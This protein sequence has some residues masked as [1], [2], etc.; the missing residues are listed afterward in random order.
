[1]GVGLSLFGIRKDGTEFPVEISLS[2]LP[3]EE[4]PMVVSAIRDVTERARAEAKFRGLVESAPDAVVIVDRTG[5]MVIVNAQAERLFGRSRDDLLGQPVETLVPPRF[6]SGHGASREGYFARPHVR[7]MDS[8]M[9]LFGLRSDGTEFPAEIS[10]SPLETSEGTLVSCAIRDVTERKRL[11]EITREERRHA[12]EASR[13]KSEFLANMSHELRTP[14]NAVIGFAE[15]MHDGK[16]GPVA[17][18]QLEFLIDILTS[19]RHLLQ[20]INDVLDLSK[21]EAGKLEF[22]LER[23]ALRNLVSQVRDTLRGLALA[24]RIAITVEVAPEV[25]EVVADPARLK[26]ILYNYISNALKFTR[27]DGHVAVRAT[28][29]GEAFYRVEVKDDGIGIAPEDQQRLFVEF[30]QLDAGSGKKYGGTGLGLALTKRLVEAQGG[31]VGVESAVG[32]GS[33][34]YA[35]L[36]REARPVPSSAAFAA[37]DRPG[38]PCILVVEDD[39]AHRT[40]LEKAL[41]RAGY[42]V[43]SAADGA[44]ARELWRARVFDAITLDLVLPDT[45]GQE[46]LAGLRG[47]DGPNRYTPVVVVTAVEDVRLVPGFQVSQVLSKPVKDE[48]LVAALAEAGALPHA[49]G[50]ILVVDDEEFARRLAEETLRPL[51]YEA[52]GVGGGA[53]ALEALDA[54]TP[55]AIVLD[56]LMPGMNG[57]EFLRRLRERKDGRRV[58]VIAWTAKEPSEEERRTLTGLAQAVVLKSAGLAPLLHEVERLAYGGP[59]TEETARVG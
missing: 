35:V 14:L 59:S 17:P 6:R 2:P 15:L 46:L 48:Q 49:P 4:G 44:A 13:M 54:A 20:L 56:L 33:A 16:A 18:L 32:K 53:E 58:P 38:A 50:L 47:E 7:A 10:L 55:A 24:K 31:H 34:F 9:D 30:Q 3:T 12:L 22:R 5:R 25:Q 51:G 57:W 11:E 29:E 26:Q 41:A 39:A 21:V 36:P 28:L 8:G 37:V 42:A 40:A 23:V 43:E 1:M 45:S 52:I 27:E 19:A